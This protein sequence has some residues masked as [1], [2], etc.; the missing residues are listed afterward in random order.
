MSIIYKELN[1]T[2]PVDNSSTCIE[3]KYKGFRVLGCLKEVF[4]N[5]GFYCFK[6]DNGIE[7]PDPNN[8]PLYLSAPHSI[9]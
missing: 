3:V 9:E 5:T 8:C 6:I 7:C 4:K 1:G 2:C